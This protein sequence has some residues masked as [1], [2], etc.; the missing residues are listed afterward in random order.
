MRLSQIKC[1]HLMLQFHARAPLEVIILLTTEIDFQHLQTH[2]I[3]DDYILLIFLTKKC[4]QNV[5]IT[6]QMN[7]L[8]A[9]VSC[10]RAS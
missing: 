7:T 2:L 3:F 9:A 10:S 8:D 1:I 6:D 5:I 4:E